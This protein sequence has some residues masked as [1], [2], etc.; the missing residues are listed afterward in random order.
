MPPPKLVPPAHLTGAAAARWHRDHKRLIGEAVVNAAYRGS[1][2]PQRARVQRLMGNTRAEEEQGRAELS[3]LEK[4]SGT[5]TKPISPWSAPA[6]VPGVGKIGDL[7]LK[8]NS[9]P[10]PR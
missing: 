6:E 1:K 4:S 10:I 5:L 2:K 3:V 9:T 8:K 7:N